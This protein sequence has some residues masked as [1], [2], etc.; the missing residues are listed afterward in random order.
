MPLAD[1]LE[2]L[3]GVRTR[4]V[5]N[6]SG[7]TAVGVDILQILPGNPNRLG[8]TILNLS[9]NVVYVAP[10]RNVS[11]TA[12]AEQGVLLDPNGGQMTLIWNEDFDLLSREWFAVATGADSQVYALEEIEY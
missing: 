7:N 6:P 9:A 10:S 3:F 11:A 12:D 8:A 5:E 1:L 2:K 4:P